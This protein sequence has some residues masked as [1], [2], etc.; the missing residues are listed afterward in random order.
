MAKSRKTSKRYSNVSAEKKRARAEELHNSLIAQVESLHGSEA[1]KKY[2]TYMASFRN[3]SA[4]NTMLVYSQMPHAT[5]VAGFRQW[6][7]RGRQVRKGE[8]AIYILGYRTRT[9]TYEEDK[10]QLK[11]GVEDTEQGEKLTR[12]QV[13]FPILAV[14]DESQTDPIEGAEPIPQI[15]NRLEGEDEQG[16]FSILETWLAGQGWRVERRG[17]RG[18]LNGFTTFGDSNLVVVSSTL[19]PAQA[20]KTLIHETAHVLLHKEVGVAEYHARRHVAETEAESVAY[21]V[22]GFF[23]LDTSDYSIGYVAQWSSG[24]VDMIK[25]VASN[26]QTATGKIID[27]ISGVEEEA[28]TQ[29]DTQEAA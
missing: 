5:N 20:L 8:K 28:P 17:L 25:R 26:V 9:I 2:L 6:Q 16:L 14:F 22:A 12:Q 1:W 27:A 10:D 23:G 3:Y 21:A 15:M 13:F 11:R 18:T 7:A 29:E 19:A 4:H 24:D